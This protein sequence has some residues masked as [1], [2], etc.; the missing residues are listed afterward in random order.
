MEEVKGNLANFWKSEDPEEAGHQV[1]CQ[2]LGQVRAGAEPP[3]RGRPTS[4]SVR[5]RL[6][7]QLVS[8]N[9]PES[10][11]PGPSLAPERRHRNRRRQGRF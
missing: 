10:P 8:T 9:G 1:Q 6:F 5:A 3:R 2:T 4:H 11:E 7:S